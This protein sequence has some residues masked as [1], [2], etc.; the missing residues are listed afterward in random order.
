MQNLDV[1]IIG[2][3]ASGFFCACELLINNPK[4][5][6][7]IWEKSSKILSKVRISGGGRCNVTHDLRENR[8]LIKK[9][10]R[11]GK[12]LRHKLNAF[13]V[14]NTIDWFES[15]GVIL[16]TE[17]DQRM[18]PISNSSETIAKCLEETFVNLGGKLR[19]N[20]SLELA[21]FENLGW[22]LETSNGDVV[23]TQYLVLAIGGLTLAKT[24]WLKDNFA[25]ETTT[26]VPSI[27]TLN[28]ADRDLHQ[29]TGLSV[30]KGRI[31]YEGFKSEYEG[32]ILITHWGLS[33]PAVLASS[34]WH[35]RDLFELNYKAIV[36]VG[37]IGDKNEDQVREQLL[38]LWL[39]NKSKSARNAV[40]FGLSR[41]LWE[42]LLQ[43]AGIPIDKT[44]S[45]IKKDESNRL[46]ENLIRMKFQVEG[47]TTYK[48]EFVTAGGIQLSDLNEN[49]SFK[50]N[51]HLYAIG[52]MLDIDGITGGFNFQ[53]AWSTA[54]VCAL[55]IANKIIS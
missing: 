19:S 8:N 32:P 7:E 20:C 13:G 6:V 24:K 44:C 10:P 41:R 43:K 47:R 23:Q 5:N 25:V 12:Y 14:Q 38:N 46:V 51:E 48:E 34:A 33:G 49:G 40:G 9:Y 27:F 54:H 29:L 45:D 35:A 11:G 52:E 37:W 21:K 26:L 42:W 4:L 2:G 22:Q 55:D 16:K 15:K 50:Q 39:E 28:I 1:V 17:S 18:F 31:K 36:Q 30:N 53:A 3:G